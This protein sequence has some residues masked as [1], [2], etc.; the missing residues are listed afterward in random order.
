M[1]IELL[2]LRPQRLCGNSSKES[3]GRRGDQDSS[4][5]PQKKGGFH[6]PEKHGKVTNRAGVF[7]MRELVSEGGQNPNSIRLWKHPA[8]YSTSL[9]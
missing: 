9:W 8:F 5:L 6:L 3:C 4:A 1:V 2:C 7:L